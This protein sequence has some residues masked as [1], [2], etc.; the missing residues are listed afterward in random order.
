MQILMV[1]SGISIIMKK[2]RKKQMT[3]NELARMVAQGFSETA[4]KSEVATKNDIKSLKSRMGKFESKMD[5]LGGRTENL[6][7]KTSRIE[8]KLDR[9]LYK[10]MARLE[11]LIR[12]IARKTKIKLEY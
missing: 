2:S 1:Y 10:E 5:K 4:K 6:E 8:A 11:E 7:I 3:L 12:Q 9:A